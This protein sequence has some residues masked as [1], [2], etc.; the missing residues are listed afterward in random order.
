MWG[1]NSLSGLLQENEGM[2]KRL[3]RVICSDE[4]RMKYP[5]IEIG[6]LVASKSDHAPFLLILIMEVGVER[7]HSS[8][9][10]LG[11]KWNHGR[12]LEIVCDAWQHLIG[13]SIQSFY[14]NVD[15]QEVF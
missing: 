13:G 5:R 3:D 8:L 15:L 7:S 9:R 11:M 14:I 4:W 6:H 1:G 12:S 10:G 2:A